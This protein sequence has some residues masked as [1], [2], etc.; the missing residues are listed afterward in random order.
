M[1]LAVVLAAERHREFI[2]HLSSQRSRLGKP[3][4]MRVARLSAADEA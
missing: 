2:A 1:Q 3:Q 4:M